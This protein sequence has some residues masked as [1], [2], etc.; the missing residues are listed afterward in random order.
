MA[1]KKSLKKHK[2]GWG[3]GNPLF[4]WKAKGGKPKR[5]GRKGKKK[6][7]MPAEMVKYF[8]L[9]GQGKSKAQARKL[10]GVG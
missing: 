5:K 6:G 2:K 7:K 9:R 8:Q 1:N 10:A 3:P 4:D